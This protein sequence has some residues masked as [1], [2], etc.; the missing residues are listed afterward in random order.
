MTHSSSTMIAALTAAALA[1]TGCAA[2]TGPEPGSDATASS[3]ATPATPAPASAPQSQAPT[4]A[5]TLIGT[6]GTDADPDAFAIALTDETGTP[7]T[8]L[9]AGDYTLTIMDP[10]AIHNFHLSGEGVDVASDVSATEELEFEITL[11]AGTYRFVC[12]PHVGT[13]SGE[14]AVTG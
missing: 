1:L 11:V 13:M 4:A 6:V 9:P 2:P 5:T 7:V 10:S 3:A 8:S 12:D 14:L